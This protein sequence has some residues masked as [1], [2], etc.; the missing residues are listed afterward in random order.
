MGT[1]GY[2]LPASKKFLGS[3]G[4]WVPGKLSLMPIPGQKSKIPRKEVVGFDFE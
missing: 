2:R 1:E 3:D 4:Y